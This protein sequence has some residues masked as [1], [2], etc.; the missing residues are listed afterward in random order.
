MKTIVF[1]ILLLFGI[2]GMANAQIEEKMKKEGVAKGS[3]FK[4]GQETEG[5]IKSKGTV[6]GMDDQIYPAPWEFQGDIKFIPKDV[7]ENTEKIKGNL[8]KKYSAKDI[9]AY[10]Y[11]DMNFESVKYADMSAVGLN[12]IPKKM[13][14]RKI[15]DDKISI[16]YHYDSPP[17]VVV[18]ETFE[19]Y[20]VECAKEHIVY[21]KGPDGKVKQVDAINGIN[22]DKDW[23]DCPYV[24]EKQANKEYIGNRLEVR[25][26][27]IEDYNKNCN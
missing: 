7:F 10:R 21:R 19:S 22:M 2:F 8:Y 4:D 14:L 18:G 17:S 12:M 6:R 11:E 5:Y 20:Y 3:I 23:E 9:D 25:L 27:A 24:K 26:M 16:F 13:F 15:A 1:T